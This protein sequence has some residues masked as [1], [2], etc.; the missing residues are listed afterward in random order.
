MAIGLSDLPVWFMQ[1][2]GF[3]I[4]DVLN[5]WEA[6]GV[7]DFILPFLL[8]FAV[9]FGA[10]TT[11]RVLGGHK[12]VNLIIALVIAL[13]AL[14]L[15]FVQIFF[16]ELFPRFGVGLAILIV[17][18]IL[19]ALFIPDQHKKG[20]AIGF[21]IAGAVIGIAVLIATL[22]SDRIYWFDS[23]FWQDY[24][25]LIIGGILLLLCL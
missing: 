11:T 7:F 20:W 4:R 18:V 8:I 24:W 14:R 5:Q 3:T 6:V 15:G 2:G 21:S 23:Y 16:T 22:S 12:G 25:G 17:V 10:L 1:Y 13:M 9:I 19:A